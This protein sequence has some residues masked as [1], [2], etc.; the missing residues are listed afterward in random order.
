L[1]R[2]RGFIYFIMRVGSGLTAGAG[3]VADALCHYARGE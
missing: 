2:R 3:A 1:S